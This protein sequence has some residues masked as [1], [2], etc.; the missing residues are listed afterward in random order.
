M[1]SKWAWI[2]EYEKDARAKGDTIR[3]AWSTS[4]TRGRGHRETD[5]ARA[6]ALYDQGRR[7]ARRLAEPWWQMFYT[8][9]RIE[10][11]CTLGRPLRRR[12][13][14]AVEA[15]WK[16]ESLNTTPSRSAS[17]LLRPNLRYLGVDAVGYAD[18]SARRCTAW[19][20]TCRG[21]P[22]PLPAGIREAALR[23]GAGRCGRNRAVCAAAVSGRGR[24]ERFVHRLSPGVQLRGLCGG[25]FK[26]NDWERWRKTRRRRTSRRRIGYQLPISECQLW[27]ALL[28]LRAGDKEPCAGRA[29]A[30]GRRA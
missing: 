12:A 16:H 19:N 5:P 26:R 10:A 6:Y 22:E 23:P 14:P 2:Q 27:K 13:G 7:L 8:Q 21:P 20:T 9:R 25:N 18:E 3:C 17:P 15:A 29:P 1:R 24:R 30:G 4:T 11:R 28:A